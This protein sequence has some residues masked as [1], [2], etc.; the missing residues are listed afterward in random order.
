MTDILLDDFYRAVVVDDEAQ[1]RQLTM[2]ALTAEGFR[3]HAA[4]DGAEALR[5]AE[6]NHYDWVV[7]DLRMPNAHG[8]ALAAN[9]LARPDRPAIMVL[10]GLLEPQLARDLLARGVDD[11]VFK[12]IDYNLFA[13]KANT[14]VRRAKA[15]LSPPNVA[16]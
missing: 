14:L 13:I 1:I 15:K 4:V 3:C 9:L 6:E 8:H 7:T 11:I 5:M 10:T 2:R 12:P 16:R